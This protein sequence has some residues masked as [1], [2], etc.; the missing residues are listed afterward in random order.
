MEVKHYKD[1]EGV[2]LKE[3]IYKSYGRLKELKDQYEMKGSKVWLNQWDDKRWIL[4]I[5]SEVH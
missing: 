5:K 2:W 3:I 4:T 1:D